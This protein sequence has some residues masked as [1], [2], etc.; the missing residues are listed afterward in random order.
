VYTPGA[1]PSIEFE[2]RDPA[3]EF[4]PKNSHSATPLKLTGTA[5]MV[6]AKLAAR[7]P[8]AGA[9]I[10]MPV[11]L[12]ECRLSALSLPVECRLNAG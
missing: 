7:R 11:Q 1:G 6:G 8:S 5:R 12:T 2:T 4:A 3:I 10:G 9:E